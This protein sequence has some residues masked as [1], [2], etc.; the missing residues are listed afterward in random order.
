MKGVPEKDAEAFELSQLPGLILDGS[1]T[2][3]RRLLRMTIGLEECKE[4]MKKEKT[5]HLQE[6][7]SGRGSKSG[8]RLQRRHLNVN[9]AAQSST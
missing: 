5:G 4:K 8:Q 9:I 7:E 3:R 2:V 6:T 1:L